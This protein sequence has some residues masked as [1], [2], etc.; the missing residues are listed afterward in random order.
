VNNVR[1]IILKSTPDRTQRLS[2]HLAENRIQWRPFFGFDAERWGLTTVHKYTLDD[3][4][5]TVEPKHV[6]LHLSHY[7]LWQ[8]LYWSQEESMT[9]LE[10]DAQF[11]PGWEAQYDSAIHN[12]PPEWD[13]LFIGS[14]NTSGKPSMQWQ[15]NVYDVRHPQTT[16][17]DLVRK[18]ALQTLLATQ[19]RAWAPIDISLEQLSFRRLRVYTVLPRIAIQFGQEYIAP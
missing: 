13:M 7:T 17:A 1:A 11:L 5:R 14:G 2:A 15:G 3:N 12:L 8:E 10:D 9:I 16:H 18:S 4:P 6:G 19:Q